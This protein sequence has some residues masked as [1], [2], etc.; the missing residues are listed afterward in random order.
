VTRPVPLELP[1]ITPHLVVN[2]AARA[3]DFY[4]AAL[5]CVEL[6]RIL[7]PDGRRISFAELL[8]GTSR[9]FL[10]DEFPEQH[11]FSPRTL[12]GTPVALHVYVP[13]VDRAYERAVRAGMTVEIPLADFFWGERYGSLR[14]PFG[15]HWALVSRTEDLSPEEIQRRALAFYGRDRS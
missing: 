3:I 8:L 7:G 15:H 13:D 14:D 9:F 4:V 6:Y 11:A 5:D 12:G 1:L 2:D 10:V